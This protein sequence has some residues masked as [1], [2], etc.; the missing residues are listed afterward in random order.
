MKIV[1]FLLLFAGF[2]VLFYRMAFFRDLLE[3]LKRS[4][5]GM[6]ASARQ[7]SLSDRK[8]LLDLQDKRT[9]WY[10]LEQQL[11][12]SGLKVRFPGITAEWWAAWNCVGLALALCVIAPFGGIAM[13]VAACLCLLLAEGWLLKQMKRSNLRKV[14]KNLME[15]LDFLGNYS[16][17]AGEVTGVLYQ[18]SRY[19]EEPL[20]TVLL[21]CYYE[22]STSGDTGKALVS[23]A[24]K[25]EHPKF[26]E[27][28]RN[29]DISVRYSA[30]F[31][32]LVSGSR[33]SMREYLRAA[34]ERRVL[35]RE[36][37]INMVLLL[38]MS[39]TVLLAVGKLTGTSMANVLTK[40]LPGRAGIVVLIVIFA[41][42]RRQM[43]KEG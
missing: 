17:T 35:F 43:G 38:A 10:F 7:R 14:E 19:M 1:V 15:M 9:S 13:G 27:L 26:K 12:Y 6:N 23:M 21:T 37:V 8:K 24:E 34:E 25:I 42:F 28:V 16:M 33:R 31:S 11:Y 18:I 36:A 30:D 5:E 4:R 39:V 2:L 41:L 3:M 29:M 32:A 20:K 40:T 22:A